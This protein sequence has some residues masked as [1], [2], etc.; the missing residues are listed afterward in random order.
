MAVGLAGAVPRPGSQRLLPEQVLHRARRPLAASA[1]AERVPVT[2]LR[3]APHQQAHPSAVPH[4]AAFTAAGLEGRTHMTATKGPSHNREMWPRA[5]ERAAQVSETDTR[6][7]AGHTTC[8]PLAPAAIRA[9][10][11]PHPRSHAGQRGDELSRVCSPD[12][13]R[14]RAFAGEALTLPGACVALCV[15]RRQR[16]RTRQAAPLLGLTA[17]TAGGMPP[18]APSGSPGGLAAGAGPGQPPLGQEGAG[19]GVRLPQSG[20]RRTCHR[21]RRHWLSA[22]APSA[23]PWGPPHLPV[24]SEAPKWVIHSTMT[25]GT[26]SGHRTTCSWRTPHIRVPG[27][28]CPAH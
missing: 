24:F 23:S 22:S 16:S 4:L 9:R 21:P 25:M 11:P 19:V 14:V 1:T 13:A 10:T 15:L 28:V 12:A 26:V 8:G 20:A 27:G 7:T 5:S 2:L 3:R 17:R 6:P 18:C